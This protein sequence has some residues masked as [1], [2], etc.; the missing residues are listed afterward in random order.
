M[1]PV[2]V[3][4]KPASSA[5]NM[6]CAYC[7]YRDVASHRQE[8]FQGMLSPRLMEEVVAGAMEFAEHSCSFL[9]QGGEPTL[10]GL[11]FYRQVVELVKKHE[12]PGVKVS[13]AIQTNAFRLDEEWCAFFKE[14]D[15]LVGVS[16][17]GPAELH[18]LNRTDPA[19]N[20]TF[21]DVMRSVAL[22]KKHGVTFNILCVLTGKNARSIER[23]YR[24][25]RKQG[26][27]HIQFIPCLEPLGQERGRER[28]HL[29]VEEY[30]EFLI[31]VFDLWFQDLL[32]GQYVSIRHID[33]WLQILLGGPARGLRHGGQVLHPVR[34]GRGRRR[35]PLRLLR[36]GRAAAGH[37]G[38]EL[39]RRDGPKRRRTAV[40]AVFDAGAAGVR[41]LPLVRTVPQRLPPG[42]ADRRGRPA[43]A[44]LLLR[45]FAAVLPR[46]GRPPAA[47]RRHPGALALSRFF[48]NETVPPAGHPAGGTVFS[49]WFTGRPG[50]LF[51]P[52]PPGRALPARRR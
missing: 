46:A 24:F 50:S 44:L 43:G 33:N 19:Q 37:G 52:R 14:H 25:F 3:L 15:F 39:L 7:F 32:S 21:N 11:D 10:A 18:N 6:T 51:P 8:G 48:Q 22:L 41:P 2:N 27:D 20:G 26:L 29:S 5:C 42:P 47:G 45:R 38:G 17:D 16:L 31:R 28:Y 4:I 36:A 30:G 1:P 35:V 9:F 23:I 49:V 13:Y 34:G 12:K 40:F